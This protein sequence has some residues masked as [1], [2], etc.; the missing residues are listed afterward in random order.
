MRRSWPCVG[1]GVGRRELRT[2]E[3]KDVNIFACD[4]NATAL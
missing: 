1:G 2:A 4:K 3:S